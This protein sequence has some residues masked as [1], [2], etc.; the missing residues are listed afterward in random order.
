MSDFQLYTADAIDLMRALPDES[1]DLIVTD[2]AYESLE[3]HRAVGTTTRLKQS[4]A[5]SNEWFPIFRNDRFADFFREAYRVLKKNSHLYF[6]CDQETAFVAKPVGEEAGF[7]FWKPLVWAKTKQGMTPDAD[8]LTVEHQAI[9]MGYH[10]RASYEFVLFFEKGKRKLTDLGVR[11][12][13]PFPG[14]R[15]GYPTE[16]PVDLN[17][18]L[19]RLSSEPGETV[20]DPF[21]GS[22][23]AGVAAV[24]NGRHFIGGDI[25]ESA[26]AEARKRLLANAA[27]D[28]GQRFLIVEGARPPEPEPPPK[29]TR[30]RR[31]EKSGEN[32]AQR[33]AE[34]AESDA[35]HRGN[36]P[37]TVSVATP[38]PAEIGRQL[39][40][41]PIPV[42]SGILEVLDALG[43]PHVESPR[44]MFKVEVS[45]EPLSRV[46]GPGVVAILEETFAGVEFPPF[47]HISG[48]LDEKAMEG[49]GP[50][51]PLDGGFSTGPLPG[52]P[53]RHLPRPGPIPPPRPPSCP[54]GELRSAC[55][56]CRSRR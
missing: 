53:T 43:V 18:I 48:Y 42:S 8:D 31:A 35:G 41:T 22:G 14:V 28:L 51:E 13:L 37:E 7:K 54:H 11:D 21:M 47:A 5:S 30:A 49:D 40:T 55:V 3:K 39:G 6:Y 27:N 9:G 44:Q 32:G 56:L 20:L 15:N 36:E 12:V 1:V 38:E 29:K 24:R 45:D 50:T 19:V 4:A 16:K 25:K 2:T 34:S 10:F 46:E 52:G 33:S 26:V 17:R 23:N